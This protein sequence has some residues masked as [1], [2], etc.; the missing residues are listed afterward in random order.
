LGWG[1]TE[2]LALAFVDNPEPVRLRGPDYKR[3]GNDF[4]QRLQGRFCRYD[5]QGDS[6]IAAHLVDM[7]LRHRG[8][9]H[10][11]SGNFNSCKTFRH[12]HS[13]ATRPPLPALPGQP[14]VVRGFA[15]ASS[16]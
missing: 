2:N 8:I 5:M 4:F 14:K 16:I 15:A 11:G 9:L 7:V 3:A 6:I 12:I 13:V 10:A 1:V